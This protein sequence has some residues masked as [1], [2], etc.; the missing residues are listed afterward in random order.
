[1]RFRGVVP[2]TGWS[3]PNAA[4]AAGT[5]II[6]TSHCSVAPGH[7]R[8]DAGEPG[9]P[10]GKREFSSLLLV[11]LVGFAFV[12]GV[13]FNSLRD[14]MVSQLF[15]T[16]VQCTASFHLSLNSSSPL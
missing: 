1:M 4:A 9:N 3:F 14:D 6:I 2:V 15:I 5:L 16:C 11:L 10:V 12:R 7:R 13:A 8:R